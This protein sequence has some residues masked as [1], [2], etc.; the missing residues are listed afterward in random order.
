MNDTSGDSRP[1]STG[2]RPTTDSATASA[3]RA[4]RAMALIH[5]GF[6]FVGI[7]NTMLGPV[8]PLL[9]ERW[10]LNDAQGGYLFT[11][12]F[13]GAIAGSAISGALMNK[14]GVM[15]VLTMGYT[16]LAV[17]IATLALSPW[18]AGIIAIA[19]VGF[20][21][22]LT[23]PATNLLVS[24]LNPE[25][26]AMALNVINLVWGI[27]AIAC[28]ALISILAKSG[29]A[30]RPLGMLAVGLA[31]VALS[32]AFSR[33]P[34][35]SVRSEESAAPWR[36]NLNSFVALTGIL[37]FL[38]V[39]TEVAVGGWIAAYTRRIGAT[40][41]S[42]WAVTPAL[43]Y[44][45]MLTG[46]ALASVLLRR[47]SEVRLIFLSLIT[48]FGGILVIILGQGLLTISV[49]AALAGLGMA[50]IFPTV[51]A[52]FTNRPGAQ[53]GSV[54]LLFV[55]ASLGGALIPWLVGWASN[56]S[57]NLRIGLMIP[58]LVTLLMIGVQAAMVLDVSPR[59]RRD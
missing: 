55:L 57:G 7:S 41:E 20:S 9:S 18:L 51:L 16:G 22:G 50:A 6:L 12:Q 58:L 2:P 34:S 5:I 17:S 25:R 29:N 15:A 14:L 46:R 4:G 33:L 35:F 30:A 49:G 32:L 37:I 38:Y 43:F 21:L 40:A 19:A 47:L 10:R 36:A 11:A 31:L 54:G 24:E 53:T 52:L 8:L 45:G 42:Y 59:R 27:G 56:V 3:A 23:N 13:T 39:G 44:S 26:R 48:T 1:Q 28:P